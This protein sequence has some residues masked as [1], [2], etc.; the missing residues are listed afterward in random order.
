MRVSFACYDD[1]CERVVLT[2]DFWYFAEDL[3]SCSMFT[4]KM[5]HAT[6]RRCG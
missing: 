3:N 5:A 1:A 4:Q 2:V 6:K